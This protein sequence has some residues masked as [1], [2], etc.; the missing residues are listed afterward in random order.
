MLG[1]TAFVAVLLPAMG[2]GPQF[3]KK[4]TG[5]MDLIHCAA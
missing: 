2:I 1:Y 3:E 4:D 5:Q